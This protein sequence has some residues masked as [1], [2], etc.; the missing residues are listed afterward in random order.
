MSPDDYEDEDEDIDTEEEA[1]PVEALVLQ[2]WD[3]LQKNGCSCNMPHDLSENGPQNQKVV[4]A[5][6]SE[7]QKATKTAG[8]VLSAY[9]NTINE[10]L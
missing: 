7:F 4:A 6:M 8:A 5:A 10:L 9:L 3:N 1:V 2:T